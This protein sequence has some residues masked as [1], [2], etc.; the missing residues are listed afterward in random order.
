VP[1]GRLVTPKYMVHSPLDDMIPFSPWMVYIYASWFFY[2]ALMLAYTVLSEGREYFRNMLFLVICYTVSNFI[3]IAFPNGIAFRPE[4]P[5]SGIGSLLLQII[6]GTDN[7]TNCFP[8]LHCSLS[9]GAFLIFLR[10]ERFP[11]KLLPL[12]FI[13]SAA[14]CYSTCA[15]K[16]HS[17]LDFFGALALVAIAW[18][19]SEL[20]SR[21]RYRTK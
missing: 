12:S 8:S 19:L 15:I 18:P 20:I 7:P 11:K 1:L 4:A 21:R 14:I 17:V 2:V 9:M 5:E 10:S 16:Q 13:Y 3:F 6:Y